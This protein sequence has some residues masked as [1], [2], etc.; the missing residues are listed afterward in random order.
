HLVPVQPQRG[1][2]R[3]A[4]LH[5]VFHQ[6]HDRTVQ[7]HGGTLV[8][9]DS[10]ASTGGAAVMGMVNRNAAPR[11]RPGSTQMRPPCAETMPRQIARPNP[12]PFSE[13]A[14]DPTPPRL[15]L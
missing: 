12:D 15:E 7:G 4:H 2:Q 11:A 10:A 9:I 14:A 13:G 6:Q 8:S 1:T 3:A 5:L